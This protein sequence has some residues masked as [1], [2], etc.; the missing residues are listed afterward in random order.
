MVLDSAHNLVE[1][2]PY[3]D[4]AQALPILKSY[5][6]MMYVTTD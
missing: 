4:Y 6:R 5:N 2:V 1:G 3:T